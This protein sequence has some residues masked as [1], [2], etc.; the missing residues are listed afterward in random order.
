VTPE[1]LN[2]VYG[3]SKSFVVAFS[4]SLKHELADKGVRVQVV[5]PGAIATQFWDV[6]GHPVENLPQQ[7]VD[8]R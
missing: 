1:L 2:G 7:M 6:A 5:L 4:Q 8:V 3:A